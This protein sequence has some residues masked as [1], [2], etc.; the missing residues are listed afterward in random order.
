MQLVEI[1]DKKGARLFRE[2]AR[3]IYTGDTNW[4]APLRMDIED[5]FNPD[6][7][8]SFK[9]GAAIRWVL[10]SEGGELIGR[11]A[12]FI[13]HHK[14]EN[15][16]IP[17]GGLGFFECIN[18]QDAANILFD[19]CREWL[20]SRGAEAMDGSINFGE[21]M[22]NWGV[23]VEGFMQQGYGMPYNK[24]YYR[25]LF[26]NYGFRDYFQ[27]LAYHRDMR[28]D[29]PER[30]EKFALFLES[31]PGYSFE[32]YSSKASEKYVNDLTNILNTTW[33]SYM[34]NF[35]PIDPK[36]IK[37]LVK[38]AGPLIEEEFIWFA[39]KDEVPVGVVVALPDFNQI[40][41]H[42]NGKIGLLD[43][44]KLLILKKRGT[45][46]RF[47]VLLA[48]IIPEYQNS[49]VIAALFLQMVKSVRQKPQYTEMELSWVGDFNPRMRKIYEQI[50]GV[51]MKKHITYRYL[52]DRE[53]PFER[54]TNEGGDSKLRK[55][56]QKKQK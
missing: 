33:A 35:S 19:A 25:E 52:F 1:N 22:F 27:Q 42:F 13:N 12:A 6:K 8:S 40:L 15:A 29:F 53:S 54:F 18:D 16:K 44:P 23:L 14:N 17:S 9:N 41:K 7:N 55:D 39:Y 50:G 5:T 45:M 2:A 36:E 11:V 4:V 10:I 47:R 56:A 46:T 28:M 3:Q 37:A 30:M 32:H 43:V 24:P 26:E 38:S 51:M 34:E 49:G 20:L 48:G 21:N 31:R